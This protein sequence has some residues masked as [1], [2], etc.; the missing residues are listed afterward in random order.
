MKKLIPVLLTL[1]VGSLAPLQAQLKFDATEKTQSISAREDRLT[2]TFNFTNNTN[3]KIRIIEVE[4]NCG[5]MKATSDAKFYEPGQSGKVEAVFNMLGKSGKLRKTV[6]L[7]TDIANQG[8]IPL[9][10][11]VDIQPVFTLEPSLLTWKMG[12]PATPKKVIVRI[13]DSQAIHVTQASP[14]KK[15]VNT[16]I[17][18]VEDGK[19]Y[20]IEVT[21][22][23]TA[24]KLN[25]AIG[26]KTDCSVSRL[27]QQ[28]A[29]YRIDTAETLAKLGQ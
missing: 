12:E 23:S 25:G 24:A 10:V 14:N 3:R 22:S 9:S 19:V 5:C 13:T 11:I 20:E 29:F 17:R 6:T 7:K 26:I 28:L 18:T 21:P 27:Q 1:L 4:S 16:A 2:T 8:E 15:G